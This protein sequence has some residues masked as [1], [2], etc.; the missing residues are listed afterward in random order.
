MIVTVQAPRMGSAI[1]R[2]TP[3]MDGM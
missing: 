1:V 3:K 2:Y